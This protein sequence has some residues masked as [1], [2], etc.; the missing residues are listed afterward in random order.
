MGLAFMLDRL[1][2]RR[3]AGHDGGWPGFVSALL[4]APDDD[5]AAIVLTNTSVA[6]EP[7]ELAERLLR[8]VLGLG[9][10]RAGAACP[11]ARS[12]GRSWS[13]STSRGRA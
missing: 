3:V 1:G 12:S 8:R 2:G 13:A 9:D 4:V 6:F 7:H 10:E 11:R 5:A